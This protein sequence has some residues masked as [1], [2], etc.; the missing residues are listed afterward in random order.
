MTTSAKAEPG[1]PA[2]SSASR[3]RAAIQSRG[4]HAKHA[5]DETPV[6]AT[7]PACPPAPPAPWL[8]NPC[9]TASLF[10]SSSACITAFHQRHIIDQVSRALF[11]TGIW[12]AALSL[13]K[14]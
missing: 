9:Y 12:P 7:G 6:A 2:A 3:L 13:W 8:T 10:A 14:A 1:E 5:T 11:L 4:G